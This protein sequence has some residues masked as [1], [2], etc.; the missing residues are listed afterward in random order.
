M[1]QPRKPQPRRVIEADIVPNKPKAL[2]KPTGGHKVDVKRSG[3]T[4]RQVD[5]PPAEDRELMNGDML[6]AS[7]PT[8]SRT[9]PPDGYVTLGLSLGATL[10][11][12]DYQSAR[13]DVFMLRN[14]RDDSAYIDASYTEMG[15]RL[16]AEVQRQAQIIMGE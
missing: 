5:I 7:K 11:V 8:S 16:N 12:G 13:V 14:V 4:V 10:N 9:V 2:P 6:N 3:E 1:P 15:Q